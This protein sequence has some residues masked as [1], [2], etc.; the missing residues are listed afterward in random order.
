MLCEYAF[1]VIP[2]VEEEAAPQWVIDQTTVDILLA[3]WQMS[4]YEMKTVTTLLIVFEGFAYFIL[5][6]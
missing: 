6:V 5:Y 3:F 2:G 1:V 4:L